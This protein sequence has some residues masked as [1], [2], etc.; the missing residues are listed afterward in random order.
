MATQL[1]LR[2]RYLTNQLLG[3]VGDED[4]AE[5][6]IPEQGPQHRTPPP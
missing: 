6:D 5:H 4:T 3:I 2:Q 1:T